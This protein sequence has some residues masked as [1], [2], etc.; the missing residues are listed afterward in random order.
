MQKIEHVA[1]PEYSD[2][3]RDFNY[4]GRVRHAIESCLKDLQDVIRFYKFDG[5][6]L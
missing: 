1:K 6:E 3:R 2:M 5:E 4:E